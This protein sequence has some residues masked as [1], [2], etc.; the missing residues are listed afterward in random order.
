MSFLNYQMLLKNLSQK[1]LFSII[2]L[3]TIFS[4]ITS[5]NQSINKRKLYKNDLVGNL[6]FT[7]KSVFYNPPFPKNNVT[8]TGDQMEDVPYKALC[9][10][11]NCETGCCVGE[12][13]T[14]T[15]GDQSTCN[16][17][18]DY[19]IAG[20]VAP[21]VIVP[22]C[23]ILFITLMMLIFIK[24]NKFSILKSFLLAFLCIFIV[25]IPYILYYARK[26]ADDSEI[27]KIIQKQK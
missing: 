13:D 5:T 19:K 8:G 20:V 22:I 11:L 4:I 15:C 6:Q 3:T 21:A 26:K 10:I 12:L 2:I 14:L 17:F 18:R 23:V 16:K 27:K 7:S 1:F 25:T 9:I 24:R